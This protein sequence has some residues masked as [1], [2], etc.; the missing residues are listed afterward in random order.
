MRSSASRTVAWT[1]V[2]QLLELF[3][4]AT[5]VEIASAEERDQHTAPV[6]RDQLLPTRAYA[7]IQ[8]ALRPGGCA[9]MIAQAWKDLEGSYWK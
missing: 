5:F 1:T 9:A 4:H 7:L 2:M 3:R 8:K 6:F